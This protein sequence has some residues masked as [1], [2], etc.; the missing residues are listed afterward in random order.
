MHMCC[1]CG[2][3]IGPTEPLH[4]VLTLAGV[5]LPLCD[6]CHVAPVRVTPLHLNDV[7]ITECEQAAE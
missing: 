5:D 4:A 1:R 3:G 6:E 2:R 7:R